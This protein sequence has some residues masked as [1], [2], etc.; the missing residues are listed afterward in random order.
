MLIAVG[1]VT[2]WLA[3]S[4]LSFDDPRPASNAWT[5]LAAVP[6][7]LIVLDVLL[8]SVVS[9]L[10]ERS[11]MIAFLLSIL[12]H[13]FFSIGSVQFIVF[14]G[15]SRSAVLNA[16]SPVEQ[17]DSLDKEFMSAEFFSPIDA[18]SGENPD[19]LMP[20]NTPEAVAA[21]RDLSKQELEEDPDVLLEDM[22]P[23]VQASMKAAELRRAE[24][25]AEEPEIDAEVAQRGRPEAKMFEKYD[26]KAVDVPQSEITD[27]SMTLPELSAVISPIREQNLARRLP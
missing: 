22:A 19:Y 4:R 3:T 9:R 24:S 11:L 15:P 1:V 7:V 6:L 2:V 8:R 16:A 27:S 26:F 10:V 12:V 23:E 13:L 5:Y 14:F 17:L 25:Q 18:Q 21:E 20:V